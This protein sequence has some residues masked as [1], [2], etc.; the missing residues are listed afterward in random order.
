M[1]EADGAL[2][3]R[4][5]QGD[6]HAYEALVSRHYARAQAVARSVLGHDPAT[7]DVVQEAFVRGYERLGQL[8]NPETYPAW[9]ATITRNQ[10]IGWL[11]KHA[12]H[13]HV[14]V[15]EH[16]I[17]AAPDEDLTEREATERRERTERLQAAM[18]K[19]RANYREI[20]Q[21]KYEAGLSYEDLAE[22]LGT[23]VANVEKRLYR[24]RRL[25]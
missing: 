11:R 16:V 12:R 4:V 18:D 2:V 25:C 3:E 8:A 13:R 14:Q 21:L 5:L 7:D 10:A 24:A 17:G 23:T 20:L 19:L 15:N 6:S 9:I 1:S 22:T